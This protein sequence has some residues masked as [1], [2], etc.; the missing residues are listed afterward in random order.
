MASPALLT[1]SQASG[2]MNA[3]HDIPQ[4]FSLLSTS[5]N[6][7]RL[8]K[9]CPRNFLTALHSSFPLPPQFLLPYTLSVYLI[10]LPFKLSAAS[11]SR[12][13]NIAKMLHADWG[14]IIPH[15]YFVLS[16][17]IQF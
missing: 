1:S 15:I 13:V 3:F 16:F 11:C 4:V 2:N 9:K 14:F 12:E 5:E 7:F 17:Q 8:S 6:M 10:F